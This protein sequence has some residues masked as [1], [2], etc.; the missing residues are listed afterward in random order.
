MTRAPEGV[1]RTNPGQ[2]RLGRA[3]PWVR[4]ERRSCCLIGANQLSRFRCPQSHLP[5]ACR[6]PLGLPISRGPW[7]TQGATPRGLGL[8]WAGLRRPVWGWTGQLGSRS[9]ANMGPTTVLS[10]TRGGRIVAVQPSTPRP[11]G[12]FAGISPACVG[13]SSWGPVRRLLPESSRASLTTDYN[14]GRSAPRRMLGLERRGIPRSGTGW[15]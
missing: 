7:R 2:A 15:A 13:G 3:P 8:C 14:P 6:A 4:A 10:P 12:V 5:Q 11:S 1:R 9:G